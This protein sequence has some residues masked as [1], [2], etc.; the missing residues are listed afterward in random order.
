MSRFKALIA[1]PAS[2]GSALSGDQ[3]PSGVTMTANR[4]IGVSFSVGVAA[5]LLTVSIGAKNQRTPALAANQV[6]RL[7]E[8][9]RGE[10]I[11]V[12]GETGCPAGT[13]K[14]YVFDAWMRPSQIAT[15]TVT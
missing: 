5:N 4:R 14:V 8:A 3:L 11:K 7:D 15:G 12:K 2:L 9:E 6:Y 1:A 13:V 10:V